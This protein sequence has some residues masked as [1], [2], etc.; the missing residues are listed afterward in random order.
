[1]L[2]LLH[3]LRQLL[4]ALALLVAR[5]GQRSL[6]LL[7]L[8][9]AL[10]ELLHFLRQLLGALAL[11]VARCGQRSLV[12]LQLCLALLELLDFLRQLLGALALLV[13]R[14]NQGGFVVFQQLFVQPQLLCFVGRFLSARCLHIAVG[15]QDGPITLQLRLCQ[16][17]LIQFQGKLPQC[18]ASLIAGCSKSILVLLQLRIAKFLLLKFTD[19][20]RQILTHHFP[21]QTNLLLDTRLL[22]AS[23]N[24]EGLFFIELGEPMLHFSNFPGKLVCYFSQFL[25]R[26]DQFGVLGFQ[27]G[28]C[29]FE[30]IEIANIAMNQGIFFFQRKSQALSFLLK[31]RGGLQSCRDFLSTTRQLLLQALLVEENLLKLFLNLVE[32]L[33]QQLVFL[34]FFAHLRIGF[35]QFFICCLLLLLQTMLKYLLRL[36][37][38]DFFLLEF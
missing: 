8:C 23:Q 24:Q 21:V 16:P 1:M 14:R 4:G 32:V 37:Q 30:Q 3:F 10:L 27:V 34:G 25:P 13:A 5:C 15:S 22:P 2:E 33:Q 12:L 26:G 19:H 38:G 11:L 9:L 36:H 7:Q 31:C 17:E 6:V 20:L 35:G 28:L 18:V 29:R